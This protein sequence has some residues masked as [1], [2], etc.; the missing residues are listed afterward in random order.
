MPLRPLTTSPTHTPAAYDFK[1]KVRSQ[2]R[3]ARRRRGA[4]PRPPLLSNAAIRRLPSRTAGVPPAN[5]VFGPQGGDAQNQGGDA[6][7]CVDGRLAAAARSDQRR[8]I[9]RRRRDQPG[10]VTARNLKTVEPPR[11]RPR[12]ANPVVQ[13][14]VTP[15][16]DVD[17][18][19]ERE[20]ILAVGVNGVRPADRTD[21]RRRHA[22]E[23]L[24]PE[25][26]RTG[27]ISLDRG[28]AV[29]GASRRAPFEAWPGRPGQGPP[30]RA[31]GKGGEQRVGVER[32]QRPQA[33][34]A[35]DT[36]AWLDPL[37]RNSRCALRD[38]T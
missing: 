10:P 25:G 33:A 16:T 35:S 15:A 18:R 3:M 20:V 30:D 23:P 21:A 14:R 37:A 6:Q 31:N 2:C 32:R 13:Q 24:Q 19:F 17:P 8:Q 7:K 5:S 1:C 12:K 4:A 28:E 29:I 22:A 27:A 34:I 38:S 26:Q 11:P 9:E 36:V